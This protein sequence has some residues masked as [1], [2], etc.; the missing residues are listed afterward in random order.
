MGEGRSC[1]ARVRSSREVRTRCGAVCGR[2][3]V[4]RC[5]CGCSWIREQREKWRR[6]EEREKIEILGSR[7]V[8]GHVFCD[9]AQGETFLVSG[10]LDRARLVDGRACG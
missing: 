10:W 2:R 4:V 1:R 6:E 8:R 7:T 3:L 5:R 9:R